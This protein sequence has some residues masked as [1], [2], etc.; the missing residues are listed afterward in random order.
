MSKVDLTVNGTEYS[1]VL[2]PKVTLAQE[3]FM[4]RMTIECA[5]EKGVDSREVPI[6]E[7]IKHIMYNPDKTKECIRVAY[8][9]S[10]D[11]IDWHN[12]ISAKEAGEIVGFF[13][14]SYFSENLRIATANLKSSSATATKSK[15][16]T[17]SKRKTTTT[18]T[19]R[20]GK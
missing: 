20:G 11:S 12:D 2:R 3:S 18:A 15:P 7:I 1:F 8:D 9:G 4:A 14:L 5:K 16:G 13:F 6:D 19:K 17:K 10:V